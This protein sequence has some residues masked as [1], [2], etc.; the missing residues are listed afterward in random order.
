MLETLQ[1][2]GT[3]CAAIFAGAALYINLVEHPAR[4]SLDTAAAVAQWAPSY[5]R[6]TLM[7][8]PL[9]VV[10]AI[11]GLGAWLLGGGVAWLMAGVVIGAV[12]PFTF[13]GIMPTNHELLAPARD[14]ASP[15][16]RMLL[17][18]WGRLHGVRSVLAFLATVI[19]LG[20]L[21]GV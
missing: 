21:L 4:L 17:Q 14:R 7:Q 13:I 12:V 16:T 18:K 20:R 1:F 5:Q 10:A 2:L 15:E 9:A 19:M 8:A 11:A 6:A 3:F